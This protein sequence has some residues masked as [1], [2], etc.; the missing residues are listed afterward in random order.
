MS[1]R[2]LVTGSR[3][4]TNRRALATEI[5]RYI[6]EN[7]TM[8]VD[9]HGL[10]V[11]W[12]TRNWTIVHGACPTGADALAED[13]AVSNWIEQEPH[14]AHWQQYGRAAGIRRNEEMVALGA[15]V[16]LA[17]IDQCHKRECR[18][19]QP[20]GSHGATHCANLAAA[21][22]IEVRRFTP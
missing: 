16:C 21:A 20:H 11:D 18:D 5:V 19:K 17:F 4:W 1:G 12:D 10:P 15:D 2:I 13:Y 6:S 3:T 22:G 7:A 8:S 9:S 14:P